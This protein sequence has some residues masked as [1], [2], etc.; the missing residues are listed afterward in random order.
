MGTPWHA[1]K[2]GDRVFFTLWKEAADPVY[3]K[4]PGVLLEYTEKQL[5]FQSDI[6]LPR[7]FHTCHGLCPEGCGYYVCKNASYIIPAEY[8]DDLDNWV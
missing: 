8:S 2:P 6:P 5:I 3:R 1:L 4:I 7:V